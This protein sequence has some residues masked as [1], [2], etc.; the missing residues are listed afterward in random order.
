MHDVAAS[1]TSLAPERFTASGNRTASEL[2][3]LGEIERRLL[4]LSTMTVHHCNHVRLNESGMKVGGHQASTASLVTVMTALWFDALQSGDRVSVK[5][6]A[7]PALYSIAYLLGALEKHDMESLRAFGGLQA[8]PSRTKNGPYIDYSTGSMGLG[9]NASVWDAMTRRYL[10]DHFGQSPAGRHYALLGDA[11]LDEGAVWEAVLDPMVGQLGAVT[12]VVDV[13]RQALDR[14]VTR[15]TTRRIRNLFDAAGWQVIDLEYGQLLE[16]LFHE[17][18]GEE[19]RQL[20]N[21]MTNREF[22]RLLR[23][24][25]Q[26]VRSAL[27]TGRAPWS[28]LSKLVD[29]LDS[30]HLLAAIRNV[31]GH[32]LP[33]LLDAFARIDDSRPTV[34]LAHTV[35]GYGLPIEA[36]ADN[37]SALLGVEQIRKLA[38]LSGVDID[39][40]WER[41]DD[42]SPEGLRCKEAAL[43]L[44]RCEDASLT[45]PSP[46]ADLRRTP[47]GRASTQQ[48]FGSLLLDLKRSAPDVAARLVTVSPDVSS[49]TNLGGWINRAGVWEPDPGTDQ[50]GDH[51]LLKWDATAKGQHIELGIAET[52]LVGLLTELGSSWSRWG[53][54][55]FPVG[56]VYDAFVTRA[57]EPWSFG[58]YSGGQSI[59]VG[60][61]AGTA[62]GPEGG[63]HQSVITPSIGLEQPG[64]VAYE[65]AFA[66]DFEWCFLAALGNLGKPGGESAYFRLSTRTVDQTL[67]AVPH[68]S[69]QRET[70]RRQAVA[71]GYVLHKAEVPAV[72]IVAM[73]AVLPEA[74]TAVEELQRNGFGADLVCVTSAD[75]LYRAARARSG[76][77]DAPEW[78]LRDLFPG[79]RALP[80]VT[81][82]DGH[83]HTLAF[84]AALHQVEVTSLG[85][86]EFGQSGDIADVFRHHGIDAAGIVTAALD[87]IE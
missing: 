45:P 24:S 13:N 17:P 77:G 21:A 25:A 18:G 12:W 10:A 82:L 41:F 75:L 61:P 16:S 4:W 67:A 7:A 79:Q 83:P 9:A 71:G 33:T 1:S 74:L 6:T 51:G 14:P 5:P 29:S 32:D 73:G 81:V 54:P 62:L 15:S 46:P 22:H 87:L 80:M 39:Q 8:Y 31:G 48:A 19:F 50:D 68:D 49:T 69:V 76:L 57:L 72:T 30:R 65:P 53:Q 36:H 78:I 43:R 55:L 60:T 11:E 52:N 20:L 37:H 66:L 63:A 44:R 26:E 84:L 85:V 35:K 59:L 64:C 86:T 58:L 70:R 27:T 3:T 40:P 28:A 2:R 38:D 42:R 34:I 23:G 47:K 56:T